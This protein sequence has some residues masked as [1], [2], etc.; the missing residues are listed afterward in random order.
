LL[1]FEGPF[2]GARPDDYPIGSRADLLWTFAA[3]ASIP[4]DQPAG[5]LFMNFL[6]G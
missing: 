2:Y 1:S 5:R 4:E 6:E 3:G